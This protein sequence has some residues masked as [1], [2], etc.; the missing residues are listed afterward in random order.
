MFAKLSLKTRLLVLVVVSLVG[1]LA[2]AALQ[3]TNLRAQLLEDRKVTL[4]SAIEIAAS[5][6]AGFQERV[7]KG[8]M[9]KEQAQALAREALRSMRYQ[10]SEYFYIYDSKAMGV[11]HP[12]RPEYEGKSHWD[13]QDKSGAYTVRDLVNAALDKS[14]YVR[15]LTVKPGG[16]DQ[17]PKLH[18][19]THYQPWDWVIGTGLY[20]DDI[21]AV[22]RAQLASALA[23][24]AVLMV[25]VA[26][27][28]FAVIRA[29]LRDIGGEPA[30]AVAVMREVAG[31]NLTVGL[32]DVHAG[33]LLGELDR[34][35]QSLRSVMAQITAGAGRVSKAAHDIN[36]TTGA[37]A[38]ATEVQ[39][40]STQS[41]AA[42]MEELTVS[43]NHISDNAGETARHASSAAEL[44][45]NGQKQ[46]SAAAD[47]L[48]NM[49][50]ALGGAA[51][52]VRTLA[53]NAQEVTRIASVIK[54][55]AGQTNLLALN[56]AIEA[57]RAGEQGRGF[58]VVADEVRGLAGR[59]EKATAEISGV[60]ERI[61]RDTLD[62]ARTM[63]EAL[64][65]A[66]KAREAAATAA[67]TLQ[68]IA[69]GSGAAES[70][71][72]DV[73]ASTREQSEA[74]SLLA[75][76]VDSIAHQVEQT[77]AEMS[78]AARAA[79]GLEQTASELDA[80][81]ARFRL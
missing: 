54:D 3:V 44:A 37:V 19:L 38:A 22:F 12:I 14:G 53:E 65:H 30:M 8:E 46:V 45:R 48:G 78:V 52:Q 20:I 64:P 66:E 4:R 47:D 33:S 40:D 15:T 50:Q 76:Q 55:I 81:T 57:A 58:A 11:M 31:G 36:A 13:R 56:A 77:G 26:V 49:S 2:L 10:G 43:I 21:D 51:D 61:Q 18:F 24:I 72:R 29:V 6:V 59:T 41:M 17:L 16:N 75:Q 69:E 9:P 73:A 60:V 34:L 42:S 74:S 5:T 39:T 27:T 62:A 28:A 32:R 67:E 79:Q 23:A 70:L 25:A 71:V 63:E 35:V 1:M 68:Q 7:A 80:L